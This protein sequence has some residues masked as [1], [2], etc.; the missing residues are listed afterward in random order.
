MSKYMTVEQAAWKF[1]DKHITKDEEW[2]SE[3]LPSHILK[4]LTEEEAQALADRLKKFEHSAYRFGYIIGYDDAVCSFY[5]QVEELKSRVE[6]MQA[7]GIP[8]EELLNFVIQRM[9][10]IAATCYN[11]A[12]KECGD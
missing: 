5:S 10:D 11:Q 6:R 1:A 2:F 3:V 7:K 12:L 8:Q 4:A 9:L